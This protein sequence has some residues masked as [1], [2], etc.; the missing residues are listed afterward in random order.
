M[1]FRLFSHEFFI[2]RAGPN[3][4]SLTSTMKGTMPGTVKRGAWGCMSW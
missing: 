4:R 2:E 3:G 1:S